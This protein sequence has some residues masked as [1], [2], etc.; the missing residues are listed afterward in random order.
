MGL[1]RFSTSDMV[2]RLHKLLHFLKPGVNRQT[3]LL[4][5]ALLWTIIGCTLMFRGVLW[6]ELDE[7]LLF[8]IPAIILGTLKSLFIL[9]KSAKKSIDRIQKLADGSCLGAVYSIKTW[10]LVLC[11]I[12]I[13]Y[14]L[15]RSQL[16]PAVVGALYCTVGWALF[17]SSRF[18]WMAWKHSK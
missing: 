17:F 9:D 5:A 16:S 2:K 10:S 11:M 15:R 14:L 3:H 7:S 12:L 8:G 18:G 1:S 6:L 13:G 4:L